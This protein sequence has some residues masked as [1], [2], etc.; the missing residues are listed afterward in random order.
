MTKRIKIGIDPGHGGAYTGTYSVS[1][2]KDGLYEKDYALELALLVR[3][4]LQRC[5]FDV[6]MTRTTDVRPGD[7]TARAQMLKDEH[8]DYGVSIHFNGSGNAAAHGC[9]VFV[10]YAE[11]QAAIEVG[12]YRELGKYFKPRVPF[13]RS[14]SVTDRNNTFD[15]KMNLS[16]RRFDACSSQKEYFGV[17][18]NSW[19]EVS[20][21]LLEVCFLTNRG[22]FET[23]LEHRAEI[24]EGIAC[25]IVEGFGEKYIP[26][27]FEHGDDKPAK[28]IEHRSPSQASCNKINYVK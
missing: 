1:T 27:N 24:A 10:P 16:T 5:G 15:K 28:K 7:V 19:P 3:E 18:R 6:Y 8:C 20:T 11:T 9:E 2:V 17:I 13:A 4:H 25:S 23:Y 22:D 26:A 21:D 14:N 12:Y